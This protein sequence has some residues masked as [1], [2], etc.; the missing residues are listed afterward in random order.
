MTIDQVIK[1]VLYTPH[2]TNKA[3]LKQMLKQLIVA[4]GGNP[5]GPVGPDVPAESVIYDGGVEV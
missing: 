4:Y 2:N 3:I 1:Y 5:D